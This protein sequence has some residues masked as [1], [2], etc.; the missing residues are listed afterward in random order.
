M[1]TNAALALDRLIAEELG[2]K[3]S[4]AAEALSDAIRERLGDSLRAVLFYGSCLREST[5]NGVLDFY[6]IVDDYPSAH[7]SRFLARLNQLLPPSV[8]Y[9]E[10]HTPS[11]LLRCKYAVISMRDFARA[12]SPRSLRTGI[13][14]RFSQPTTA[15]FVRDE[16]TARELRATI[17]RC[18]ETAF[19]RCLPL[20]PPRAFTEAFST[21]RFWQIAFQY[22]YGNEM[23]PETPATIRRLFDADPARYSRV[24]RLLLQRLA[25][26]GRIELEPQGRDAGL[27]VIP[28][29]ESPPRKR[30]QH[31]RFLVK[32]TYTMQLLA[33]ALTFRDWFPYVLFKLERHS[34]I[35]LP[36]SDRQRRHPLLFGWPIFWRVL[37]QR[38]LR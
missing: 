31:R 28:R 25:E 11:E 4:R 19:E 5:H 30:L 34:G 1:E 33:T 32:S 13:W 8:F 27:R 20:L 10:T 21:S 38:I 14:A 9:L 2:R 7:D 3:P 23:R 16:T 22:T 24:T 29:A 37:R 12:A 6:A 18:L 26:Q 17:A 35:R 36:A 15:V